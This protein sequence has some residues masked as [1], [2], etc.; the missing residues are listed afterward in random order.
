[1]MK[2]LRE[3]CIE[4]GVSRRGLQWYEH[5]GLIH[6]SGHNERGH[7]LYDADTIRRIRYIRLLQDFGFSI[8]MITTIIDAPV[9][10]LKKVLEEQLP[11]LEEK[12][13]QMQEVIQKLREL[14]ESL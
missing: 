1:M 7:L 8:K 3:T 5:A 6:P 12:N 13:S 9:P 10:E 2:T 14:I 4:T 11:K